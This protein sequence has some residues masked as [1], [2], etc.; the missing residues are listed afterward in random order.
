MVQIKKERELEAEIKN[1]SYRILELDKKI[2]KQISFKWNILLSIAKGAGYAV[3]ATII[4][5]L[6]VG[7]LNWTVRSTSDIPMFKNILQTN[8]E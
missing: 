4:A 5:A 7:I 3:G 6:L 8:Q 1:L 2:E